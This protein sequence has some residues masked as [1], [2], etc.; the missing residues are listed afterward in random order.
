[1]HIYYLKK[2]TLLLLFIGLISFSQNKYVNNISNYNQF[3][4]FQGE[5]L[6]HKFSNIKSVKIIYSFDSK[7]IYF[8]NS[9]KYK[10]HY[11][12]CHE[13][14]GFTDEIHI[15]NERNYSEKLENRDYLLANLNRIESS[16]DWIMELAASDE[17]NIKY[18]HLFFNE[19]K[20]NVYFGNK[21]KFYLST[22]RLINLNEHKK[23]SIPV[24]YSDFIFK[25]ITEQS[26]EK[27]KTIGILKKY[28]LQNKVE[29]YPKSD[30]I[31]I[32]NTTPEI[33][34]NVKGIIVTELQTPLSHLVLLAK[35]RNIP[36]YVNTKAWNDKKLNEFVN[37]K[38]EFNVKEESFQI[39]E[40][41]KAI[42]LEKIKPGVYL[43][44]DLSIKKIIDLN[45]GL[46]KNGENYIGTKAQ[47]LAYLK[48]IS[49]D[50]KQFKTPEHLYA[51]PFYFYE[52]HIKNNGIQPKIDSLLHVSKDSVKLI[53]KKLKNLRKIIKTTKVNPSLISKIDSIVRKQK[54]F[55]SFKFRSSTNAE[56]L[57]GFNGAGLY[58]SKSATLDD[59]LKT[60][61]KAI[62]IVWASLWNERAFFEREL[63]NIDHNS[64]SVGVLIQRSFPDEIANGVLISKNLYRNYNGIT[65]N[66]QKG[67]ESVVEP[68][69]GVV[70]DEFYVY[71]FDGNDDILSIDYRSTSNLNNNIPIL[72]A[73]EIKLLFEISPKIERKLNAIWRKNN[74]SKKYRPL[75][76]EFK[77]VGKDRQLY[78]KQA[79]AYMD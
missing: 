42:Q 37:K 69:D 50:I 9:V 24:I 7:K 21:L 29:F 40:T 14:L 30:E 51:I 75:D 64:S 17:M 32:I 63:F 36:V 16:D 26:I 18:I 34:P 13:V 52:E 65:V 73:N 11:E 48:E 66:V 60:I 58:D 19:I 76:V 59:S 55:K 72:H 44:K 4:K 39:K 2:A 31:I 62:Q 38:V 43:N 3:L 71:D 61:E 20:Q 47:N 5:P 68:K 15:F 10:Y 74:V 79:R 8:F 1:M 22:P 70:C 28:D 46:I 56:D 35:N 53:Q 49:K 25:N 33:I 27:G 41:S 45:N 12:F 6:S 77:I 54:E 78:I 57:D 67:E 23:C